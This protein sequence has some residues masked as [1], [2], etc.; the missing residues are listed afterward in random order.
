MSKVNVIS[1]FLGEQNTAVECREQTTVDDDKEQ[2]QAREF[3]TF[4][5]W[6]FTYVW[7]RAAG[8]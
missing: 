1:F 4:K 8:G 6:M 2:N 7:A 3:W 5:C